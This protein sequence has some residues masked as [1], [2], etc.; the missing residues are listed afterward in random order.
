MLRPVAC[1]PFEPLKTGSYDAETLR[2]NRRVE[3]FTTDYTASDYFPT[4]TVQ[5]VEE[6]K[7]P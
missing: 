4:S 3:I 5:A 1:G 7:K 2:R 6:D